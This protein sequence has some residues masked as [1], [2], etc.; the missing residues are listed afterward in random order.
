M[1]PGPEPARAPSSLGLP[2]PF[3]WTC[4]ARFEDAAAAVLRSVP[5]R[6]VQF[7]SVPFRFGSTL[8]PIKAPSGAA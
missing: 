6:S 2:G 1:L 4:H 8:R 5:L 3:C 7:R